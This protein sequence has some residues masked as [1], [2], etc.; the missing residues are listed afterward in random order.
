MILDFDLTLE[1]NK[2]I[3]EIFG[4]DD[5]DDSYDLQ[6]NMMDLNVVQKINDN[7]ELFNNYYSYVKVRFI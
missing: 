1:E 2:I 6:K 5:L 7:Y 4:L 3:L